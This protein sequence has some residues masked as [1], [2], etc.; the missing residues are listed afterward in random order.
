[1]CNPALPDA[2]DSSIYSA[3]SWL[4]LVAG[5]NR[6]L[7]R[8]PSAL[9]RCLSSLPFSTSNSKN[10]VYQY[11]E[12]RAVE[13]NR[14]KSRKAEEPKRSGRWQH[15]LTPLS[16]LLFSA[17]V[18]IEIKVREATSSDRWGVTDTAMSEIARATHNY[19]DYPA[20]VSVQIE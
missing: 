12:V 14:R 17:P 19:N 16:F 13:R 15:H 7:P 8:V 9:L 10:S 2:F 20:L 5:S 3:R 18:Q 1:M 4:L 6:R 11:N